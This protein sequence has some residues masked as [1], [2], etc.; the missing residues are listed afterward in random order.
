MTQYLEQYRADARQAAPSRPLSVSIGRKLRPWVNRAIANSSLVPNSP[1]LDANLFRWT[2][3]LCAQ[4]QAI[5]A[6]AERVIRHENAIPPLNEISPDHAR[7]AADGKWRSFFLY[8]YGYRIDE[9]CARAPMTAALVEQIPGLNSAFFSILAP[10]CHIPRHKGVTKGILTCHLGLR[11]PAKA[12]RC[13]MRVEDRI[14]HWREG[15]CLVFDDSQQHEVWND[16]DETRVV[17]LLQ[18]ARPLRFPGNAIA[19]LFLEGVRRTAFVQEARHNLGDWET[20][21]RKAEAETEG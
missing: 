17:L 5:R 2:G 8:G 3:T 19:R 7:I 16:T 14:V 11:V 12:A 1:V 6:E 4:W 21:Y 10:G 20:A 18:F 9:N 13:R 15:E